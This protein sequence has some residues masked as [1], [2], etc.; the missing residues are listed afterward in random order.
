VPP[1]RLHE[2]GQVPQHGL[3]F[4]ISLRA[5]ERANEHGVPGVGLEALPG[6]G[7]PHH[8]GFGQHG[9]LGRFE[10][11][12]LLMVD[13]AGFAAG[14]VSAEPTSLVDIAPTVLRHL[15][16]PVSGTD[17]RALQHSR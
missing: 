4:A 7:K 13:G 3:A 9:G 8:L 1:D 5:E 17:G 2:V 14:A 6:A 11:A 16:L 10:Q 12:P 15:D